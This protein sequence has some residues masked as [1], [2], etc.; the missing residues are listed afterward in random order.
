MDALALLK[1]NKD[2]VRK[3]FGIKEIGLFGSFAKGDARPNSDV[4]ILV[5]FAAPVD[6]FEFLDVK[7]YLENLFGRRVDLVTQKAL[8]PL[9]TEQ[10]LK[11]VLYA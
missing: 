8:K 2:I 5:E 7:E 1:E 6:I 9:L 11:E 4:D 3:K 10:I